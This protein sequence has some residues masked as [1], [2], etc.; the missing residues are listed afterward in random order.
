MKLEDPTL[1][2]Q[3]LVVG[4]MDLLLLREPKT[5][6][7]LIGPR[8]RLRLLGADALRDEELLAILLSTGTRGEPVGA[9]A[10][11]LQKLADQ[12][13]GIDRLGLGDLLAI[14]GLGLGKA[15][16]IVAAVELGR[17]A[18]S[19][20]LHHGAPI[21][22]S[23][24]V[25]AAYRAR[26]GRSQTEEF[27]ALP[28]DAKNRPTAE[29]RLSRGGVTGCPVVPADIFRAL[30]RQGAVSVIFLHNHPSGESQPSPEDIELTHRLAAAGELLGIRVLDHIIIGQA[31]HFSFLDAGLLTRPAD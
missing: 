21:T 18:L 11:R 8:E 7:L 25:D 12:L 24:D 27:L 29:L 16:R 26:L 22:T 15:S 31:G 9:M 5:G 20:P 30:L 3:L 2:S 10:T 6:Y 17:R 1:A 23:A 14:P 19:K 13:G 28:L 4:R